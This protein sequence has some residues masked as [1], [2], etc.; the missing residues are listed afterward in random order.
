MSIKSE[1]LFKIVS[2]FAKSEWELIDLP[3]KMWL[4][5][6]SENKSAEVETDELIKALKQAQKECGSC[7]CDYDPLYKKALELLH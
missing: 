5:T 2:K 4:S 1:E 7:G 6:I 3:S